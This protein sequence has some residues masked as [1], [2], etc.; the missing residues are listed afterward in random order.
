MWWIVW[1]VLVVGAVVALGLILRDVWSRAKEFGRELERAQSVSAEL[2]LRAD[3][4]ER[5]A[6]ENPTVARARLDDDPDTLRAEYRAVRASHAP[7]RAA[8]A[9]RHRRTWGRWVRDEWPGS[10]DGQVRTPAR[11]ETEDPT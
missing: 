8:R 11:T 3:E 1:V 5:V 4:L 7:Q 9:A 10:Y 6:A 2:S